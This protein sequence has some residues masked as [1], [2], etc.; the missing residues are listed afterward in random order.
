M[1]TP[2]L[3]R[4][5]YPIG[6]DDFREVISNRYVFVDKSLFIQKILDDVSKVILITRPRR[7][8]KTM[9]LTKLLLSRN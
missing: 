9:K 1:N 2:A 8:G 5:P 7:F 3:T 6:F 4:Q